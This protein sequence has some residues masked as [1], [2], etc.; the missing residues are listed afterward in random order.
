MIHHDIPPDIFVVD[1]NPMMARLLAEAMEDEG[2][3][4]AA[5][6]G[7][8]VLMAAAAGPPRLVLLDVLMPGLD[9]PAISRRLRADPRTAGVAIVFVSALPPA[10]LAVQLRDCPYDALIAKP[11]DLDEVAE[12]VRR[13]LARA[14]D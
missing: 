13:L 2:Y 7:E 12:T 8:E 14:V 11:F 3:R 4:V 1:D 9:G 5:V 10:T 6:A